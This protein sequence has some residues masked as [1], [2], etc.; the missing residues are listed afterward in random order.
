[1]GQRCGG[2]EGLETGRAY[3]LA[4]SLLLRIYGERAPVFKEE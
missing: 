2:V 3:L 4:A 1:M